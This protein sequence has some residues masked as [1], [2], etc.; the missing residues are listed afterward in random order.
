MPLAVA[1]L[2]A[3]ILLCLGF[4][5]WQGRAVA[6]P[7][8]PSA[9]LPC[10]SYA[11]FRGAQ[12]PFDE[13]LIIPPRQIR[14][15]LAA[16]AAVT[17]CVRIYAVDQGLAEVP[18]IARELGLKV[19][20]GA[21]L[22]R[23]PRR[24][25]AEIATVIDLANRYQD[26]V[27][28]VVVGNEVLLRREMPAEQLIEQ[29]RAVAAAV[30]V[31]VTYADVWEF[32]LKNPSV[33]GSVD[34]LTVHILPYWED[35]PVAV[36]KAVDHVRD[37]VAVIREAFPGKPILI[38]ETGWPSQGRMRRDALPGVVNQAKFVREVLALA[39]DQG[40]DINIIEALDQPW[41]R[42][43]EGTVGGYWGVYSEER[44][45]KFPMAGP[46][47]EHPHWLGAFAASGAIA[48]A[49]IVF[50]WRRRPSLRPLSWLALAVVAA[51]T[52]SALVLAALEVGVTSRTLFDWGL[53][54]ARLAIAA[55]A[56]ALAVYAYASSAMADGHGS[57]APSI[58]IIDAIRVRSI[59]RFRTL[60]GALGLLR[61]LTMFGVA[62]T[63]LCLVFDGRYRDFPVAAY[64]PAVIAFAALAFSGPWS[65]RDR[66]RR[67]DLRE[68]IVF[69]SVALGGCGVI[70]A[71]EGIA[72]HQA[73]QW[74]FVV[75]AMAAAVLVEVVKRP[76]VSGSIGA[77]PASSS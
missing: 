18:A 66:E 40:I 11:P 76:Q 67:C 50:A 32:W 62:A 53:G 55:C 44:A 73:L 28:A 57:P 26:T 5:A 13:T 10:V 43:L 60:P 68:E 36:D 38:G 34:F 16:L 15:D 35:K 6:L 58:E 72:N 52:G 77:A 64:A 47:S 8:A 33:A 31:P 12:S 48:I 27:K 30:S 7:N 25:A 65:G 4:W 17:R 1:A 41:K 74:V 69:A 20:L 70:F 42:K 2:L 22:R 56:A 21:W 3:A 39:Q 71:V 19:L 24:N 51:T 59:T 29:I 23:D 14:E 46:V 45:A 54:S 63:T 37:I 9:Q 49:L 61:L 75:V